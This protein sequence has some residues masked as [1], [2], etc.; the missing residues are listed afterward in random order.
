[1]VGSQSAKLTKIAAISATVGQIGE[2]M[3]TI[4]AGGNVAD[5]DSSRRHCRWSSG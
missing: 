3:R 5:A 1:M 4:Q 2:F